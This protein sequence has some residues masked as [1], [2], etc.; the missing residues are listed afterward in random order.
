MASL[1]GTATEQAQDANVVTA[2]P[3]KAGTQAYRLEIDEFIQDSAVT[4]LF[5]LALNAM[6]KHSLY[7]DNG[8]IN[9]WSYYSLGG[10]HGLPR[11]SWAGI[12]Q[13]R[14]NGYCHHGMDTFPTWHR[15]YMY[16]FEQAIYDNMV[17]IARSYTDPAWQKTYLDACDRFKLPYW[18]VCMP[19]NKTSEGATAKVKAANGNIWRWGFPKIFKTKDVFVRLP[20]SPTQLTLMPNPLYQFSF[21]KQVETHGGRDGRKLIDWNDAGLGWVQQSNSQWKFD[22]SRFL[23]D[24]TARTPTVASGGE[25]DYAFLEE[26]IQL[27]TQVMATNIWHLLNPEEVGVNLQTRERVFINQDKPW[28][29]FASHAA[30]RR[31]FAAQSLEGWHDNIHNLVGS[32]KGKSGAMSDPSVAAFEPVFWF[33]HNNIDR[34]FAIFQALYPDKYVDP[35]HAR[36]GDADGNQNPVVLGD[37]QL[38]PFRAKLSGTCFTS[39]DNIVKDWTGTGY[40]VPGPA[41]LEKAGIDQIAVYLRDTY[42]WAT[43]AAEPPKTLSWPKD[44]SHVEALTGEPERSTAPATVAIKA[45]STAAGK[46]TLVARSLPLARKQAVHDIAIDGAISIAS[47]QQVMAQLPTGAAL[48]PSPTHPDTPTKMRTWNINLRVKKYA[49]NGSFNIHFF[50]GPVDDAKSERFM[51]RMNEV[52]FSGVFASPKGS[53]CTNCKKNAAMIYED[54]VPLTSKLT[55]YLAASPGAAGFLPDGRTLQSLEVS[56]V[57]PFLKDNLSWKVV[58]T[59]GALLRGVEHSGLEVKV[60]DRLFTPPSAADPLGVYEPSQV[61]TAITAGK[62]GGFSG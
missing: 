61:H 62:V 56:D 60:T 2:I 44:L 12:K 15:P 9:W 32:G 23:T 55:E 54:T 37:D 50:I 42:Y 7:N 58:D 36:K 25:S 26:A 59:A 30:S 22:A 38:Y 27:Q 1:P 18:D 46:P 4:N 40:A 20:N 53:A 31:E 34:L 6:Y 57:V 33:H 8:S 48:A 24:H 5:L 21:P 29:V 28:S 43:D 51:T 17:S 3:V 11:E 41:K 13:D 19:R 10:I 52:G 39:N 35:G 45:M 47:V 49:F 16:Q 14:A